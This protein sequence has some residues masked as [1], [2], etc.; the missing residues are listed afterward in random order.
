MKPKS[1]YLV[2]CIVGAIVPWVAVAPFLAEHGLD[3]PLV[4]RNLFA[5]PVSTSFASDMFLSAIAFWTFVIIEGRRAGVKHSW[6]PIAGTLV[7]GLSFGLPLFFYLREMRE[8]SAGS[9]YK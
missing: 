3:L 7:V 2:L 8:A 5:N 9:V 6:A 1:L 4:C